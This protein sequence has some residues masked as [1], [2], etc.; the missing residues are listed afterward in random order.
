[1]G[2]RYIVDTKQ[3]DS[4]IVAKE[5]QKKAKYYKKRYRKMTAPAVLEQN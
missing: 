1:M 4:S 2:R 5:E 3:A